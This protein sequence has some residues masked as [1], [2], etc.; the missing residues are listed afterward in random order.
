MIK[1]GIMALILWVLYI[2]AWV[3]RDA[4]TWIGYA[5]TPLMWVSIAVSAVFGVCLVLVLVKAII[6]VVKASKKD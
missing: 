6:S 4:F 5:V 3:Y 2:T 1:S